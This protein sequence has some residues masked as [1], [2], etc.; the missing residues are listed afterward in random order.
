MT[1]YLDEPDMWNTKPPLL[2]WLQVIFMKLLGPYGYP[3]V[4][5]GKKGLR[6]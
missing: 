3:L 4:L 2:V 1:Y 6:Q 5:D